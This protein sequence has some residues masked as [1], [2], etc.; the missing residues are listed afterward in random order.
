MHSC[1]ISLSDPS[2]HL[3][4]SPY[5]QSRS[6]HNARRPLLQEVLGPPPQG[7]DSYRGLTASVLALSGRG[8]GYNAD[9]VFERRQDDLSVQA[10]RVQTHVL[11]GS[12]LSCARWSATHTVNDTL[13]LGSELQKSQNIIRKRPSIQKHMGFDNNPQQRWST[14]AA[15][16]LGYRLQTRW[17]RWAS[18][19]GPLHYQDLKRKESQRLQVLLTSDWSDE[20]EGFRLY[21]FHQSVDPVANRR[22]LH[23]YRCDHRQL[24]NSTSL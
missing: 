1:N 2:S 19:S 14:L 24:S 6:I 9:D 16:I 22:I 11:V 7:D 15:C 12:T 17:I 20:R 21:R 23:G 10:K 5:L 18:L 8:K 13:R 3:P 4:E